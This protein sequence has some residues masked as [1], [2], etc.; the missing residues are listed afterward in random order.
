MGQIL[1]TFCLFSFA[2]IFFRA[3]SLAHAFTYVSGMFSSSEYG[4]GGLGIGKVGP[5]MA[6]LMVVEWINRRKKHGLQM[7]S[8]SP[9][10]KWSVYIIMIFIII[11]YGA[12]NETMFIYFQF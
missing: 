9:F 8:G 5:F 7:D 3:S 10:L 11:V 4:L 12:F 1:F 2:G 6:L